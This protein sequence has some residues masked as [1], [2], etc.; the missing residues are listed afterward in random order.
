MATGPYAEIV[1][2]HK[3]SRISGRAFAG[4][5]CLVANCTVDDVDSG[6][7]TSPSDFFSAFAAPPQWVCDVVLYGVKGT[8]VRA[9]GMCGRQLC[10]SAFVDVALLGLPSSPAYCRFSEG[11][12]NVLFDRVSMKGQLLRWMSS[13]NGYGDLL[14]EDVVLKNCE[15]GAMDGYPVTD[16]SKGLLLKDCKIGSQAQ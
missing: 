14:P 5:D 10:D 7:P 9:S 1:R 2:S 6:N 3:V 12:R 16:G 13:K 15:F 4:S 8:G 11:L